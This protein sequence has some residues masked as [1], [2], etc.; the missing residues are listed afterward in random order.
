MVSG[1]P[2]EPCARATAPLRE[3]RTTAVLQGSCALL[4]A[5][6]PSRL[7]WFDS[8]GRRF[9]SGA[10]CLRQQKPDNE[11]ISMCGLLTP[12]ERTE[13]KLRPGKGLFDP[14]RVFQRLSSKSAL[15]RA[16]R[17]PRLSA[18]GFSKS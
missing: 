18:S 2:E 12:N 13:T 5:V 10:V 4:K 9:A 14:H 6:L 7:C 15:N 11:A 3:A 17:W 16:S 1:A 8:G